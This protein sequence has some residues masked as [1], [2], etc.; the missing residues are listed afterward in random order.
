[1]SYYMEDRKHRKAFLEARQS[2]EVKLNL[3]EQRQQQLRLTDWDREE[4]L[5]KTHGGRTEGQKQNIKRE[6]SERLVGLSGRLENGGG[7]KE[8]VPV[9]E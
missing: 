3:E 9:P 1:M 4:V 2:M 8:C 5:A 7:N 6:K